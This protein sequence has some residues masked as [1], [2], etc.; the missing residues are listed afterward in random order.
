MHALEQ[1]GQSGDAIR[2]LGSIM[3]ACHNDLAADLMAVDE[4]LRSLDAKLNL[5]K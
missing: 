4:V 3:T 5:V 2:Q 1:T